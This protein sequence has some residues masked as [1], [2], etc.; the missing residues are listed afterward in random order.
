MPLF[1]LSG[2]SSSTSSLLSPFRG[3]GLFHDC[4]S[5]DPIVKKANEPTIYVTAKIPNTICHCP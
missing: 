4:N 1:F 3:G 2:S 5:P